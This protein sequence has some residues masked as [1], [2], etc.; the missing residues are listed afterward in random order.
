MG[1][2]GEFVDF[3]VHIC[4]NCYYEIRPEIFIGALGF[5]PKYNSEIWEKLMTFDSHIYY[6]LSTK[7][8]KETKN[9]S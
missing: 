9:H 3:F 2:V 7:Y 1:I 5:I 8:L 6:D 4:F